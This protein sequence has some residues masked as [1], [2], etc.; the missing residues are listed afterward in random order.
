[1][2]NLLTSVLSYVAPRLA[3]RL[4]GA[5]PGVAMEVEDQPQI[6]RADRIAYRK[7]RRRSRAGALLAGAS[8]GT[9]AAG[10][11]APA[12]AQSAEEACAFAA[13]LRSVDT[14]SRVLSQFP[15]DACVP[16]LLAEIPWRVLSRL[17]PELVA[18]LPRSVL[19]QFPAEV[20]EEYGINPAALGST[21]SITDVDEDDG[22]Y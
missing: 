8:L 6:A 19:Q 11:A 16:A 4:E 2:R 20:L 13:S 10:L 7:P 3:L 14:V 21:R 22:A 18:S 12:Y 9:I 1:M 5:V 15:N 17:D